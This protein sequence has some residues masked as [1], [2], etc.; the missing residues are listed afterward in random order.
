LYLYIDISKYITLYTAHSNIICI[1]I[2][3][4]Q[5]EVHVSINLDDKNVTGWVQEREKMMAKDKKNCKFIII[6][7]YFF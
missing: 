6:F 4:T 3:R 7:I 2:Y 5:T 1:F